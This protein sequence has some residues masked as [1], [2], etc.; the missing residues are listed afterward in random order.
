MFRGGKKLWNIRFFMVENT[1]KIMHVINVG[2]VLN[3]IGKHRLAI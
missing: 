3:N 2:Q 1:Q